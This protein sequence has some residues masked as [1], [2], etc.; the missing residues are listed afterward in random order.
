MCSMRM[1]N[2][3]LRLGTLLMEKTFEAIWGDRWGVL[4]RRNPMKLTIRSGI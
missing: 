1:P 3:I 4:M 2:S